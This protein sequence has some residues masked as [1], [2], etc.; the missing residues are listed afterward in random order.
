[1]RFGLVLTLA[2][3]PLLE[4]ALLIKVGQRIGPLTVILVLG[5]SAALGALVLRSQGIATLRRVM[6]AV[7]AGRPPL[8]PVIDGALTVLAGAL[9]IVP[10]FITD[11]IGAL[12]LIPALRARIAGGTYRR[13]SSA[14]AAGPGKPS[15]TDD[16][17]ATVIEGEFK[18][19]DEKTIPVQGKP[20]HD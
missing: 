7:E 6:A 5:L 14:I 4:L 8:E 16:P 11:V 1:M 3:V 20:P 10:G 19:L 18:R 15:R 12:L 9:L 17:G 13:M 2:A